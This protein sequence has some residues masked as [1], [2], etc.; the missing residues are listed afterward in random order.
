ML[1]PGRASK[2]TAA[3]LPAGGDGSLSWIGGEAVAVAD[4]HANNHMPTEQIAKAVYIDTKHR[5]G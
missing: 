1:L 2:E 4:L 5:P 3:G